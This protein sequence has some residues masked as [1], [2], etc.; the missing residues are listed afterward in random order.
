MKDRP[1]HHCQHCGNNVPSLHSYLI[2]SRELLLCGDCQTLHSRAAEMFSTA[3][4]PSK[5]VPSDPSQ[6]DPRLGLPNLHFW[7]W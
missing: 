3:D 7:H 2:E 1:E 6:P 5:I 4:T